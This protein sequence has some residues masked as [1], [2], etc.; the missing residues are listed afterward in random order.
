MWLKPSAVGSCKSCCERHQIRCCAISEQSWGG[1]N[2]KKG[3]VLTPDVCMPTELVSTETADGLNLHGAF[4][5]ANEDGRAIGT[6]L[7]IPGVAANFYASSMFTDLQQ[8]LPAAGWN[9]L[10]V[11]T[12]GHDLVYSTQVNGRAMRLGAAYEIVADA[13]YDFDAWIQYLIDQGETNIVLFG[14]SLGAVKSVFQTARGLPEQVVGVVAASPPRLAGSVYRKS[15]VRETYLQSLR[16][17]QANIEQDQPE[18][19]IESR[20]P[21]PLL[22][23]SAT[24]VD[25]YGPGDRYDILK[26]VA[27]INRPMRLLFGEVEV[28]FGGVS[29]ENLPADIIERLPEDSPVSIEVIDGANHMYTGRRQQL[30]AEIVAFANSLLPTLNR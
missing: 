20:F 8:I 5:G 2:S 4:T 14:H 21:V 15:N 6:V 30:A 22:V 25:K 1:Y 29:F 12:R 10:C 26:R 9:T 16:E 24:Y 18:A 11:N 27:K 3:M 17:A 19:L 13:M 7:C 23:S 28:R